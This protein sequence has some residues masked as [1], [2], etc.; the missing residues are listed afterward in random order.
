MTS[1]MEIKAS[2][3]QK[4]RQITGAGLMD[5]KQ[6]LQEAAGDQE[7]AIRILREKGIAKSSKR[8][9][10]VAAEGLVDYWLSADQSEG[11]MIELNCETDFVARN[12][13][14]IAL[15]K[16]IL[17]EIKKNLSWTGAEQIPTEGALAL[18]G[19]IG[20]KISTKRFIRYKVSVGG[21]VAAYIHPGS[22]LGVLIQIDSDK[23]GA[24]SGDMKTLGRELAL[25]VAG[26]NPLYVSRADVPADV[27]ER[28]KEITKKQMEGQKKPP[29]ILEKIA[30]GKLEQFFEVQCLLDQPHVR[31]VSGKTKVQALVDAVAKK[32]GSKLKVVQFV[33][34][35]VGAE[36]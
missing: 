26:A 9:D 19:K 16:T 17:Q 29:E 5:C 33:R 31:D 35:R 18:S 11:I 30:V 6:A 7:K 36:G 3:V 32:E 14:F 24:P 34:Y 28:E 23:K 4:L 2:D 10:R 27:L 1:A 8:A 15:G 22:K 13:E 25:Q 12:E 21:V 20:E